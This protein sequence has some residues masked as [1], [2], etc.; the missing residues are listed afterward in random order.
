MIN[1]IWLSLLSP[2]YADFLSGLQT[3]NIST[4]FE[5][6]ISFGMNWRKHVSLF[7]FFFMNNY[8]RN[9]LLRFLLWLFYF[10]FFFENKYLGDSVLFLGNSFKISDFDLVFLRIQLFYQRFF[11]I[12]AE[13]QCNLS[14]RSRRTILLLFAFE[15]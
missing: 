15:N 9:H 7:L 2:L 1:H 12:E 8:W 5:L 3:E 11:F 4:I 13:I 6:M 14:K 10:W